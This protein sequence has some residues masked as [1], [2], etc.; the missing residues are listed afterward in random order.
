MHQGGSA[1]PAARTKQ[2]RNPP[3]LAPHHHR[4]QTTECREKY[5]LLCGHTQQISSDS[6]PFH[7]HLPPDEQERQKWESKGQQNPPA[8]ALIVARWRKVVL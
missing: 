3:P 4:R 7:N 1:A 5:S 6:S 8:G 2:R